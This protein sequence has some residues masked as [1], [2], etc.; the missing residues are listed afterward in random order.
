MAGTQAQASTVDPTRWLATLQTWTPAEPLDALVAFINLLINA[1]GPA[2]VEGLDGLIAHTG[3]TSRSGREKLERLRK[4]SE[5][6]RAAPQFWPP[7]FVRRRDVSIRIKAIIDK[8]PRP[9]NRFEV[10]RKYRK[11][12]PVPATG[13]S[14]ELKEMARRGEIDRFGQG[15]YWRKGTAGNP[16]ESQAQQIY[17]LVHDAPGHRMRT[18]E[19]VIVCTF[20]TSASCDCRVSSLFAFGAFCFGAL[21]YLKPVDLNG[22]AARDFLDRRGSGN[23]GA[24]NQKQDCCADSDAHSH[25]PRRAPT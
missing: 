3:A 8:A 17:R 24:S 11:F 7:H 9:L 16:H 5:K 13:L 4:W 25:A 10:E 21:R 19:L 20:G 22:R 14:Q 15:L 18:A 6:M 12:A 23:D 2:R 1:A